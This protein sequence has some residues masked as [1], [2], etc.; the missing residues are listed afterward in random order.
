MLAYAV[1]VTL[2]A[3]SANE[4]QGNLKLFVDEQN[5]NNGNIPKKSRPIA[6]KEEAII[7]ERNN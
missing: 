7:L 1:S 2:T 6:T 3:N 4:L 5:R